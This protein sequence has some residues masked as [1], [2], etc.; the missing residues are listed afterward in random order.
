MGELED[1]VSY[2]SAD[3]TKVWNFSYPGAHLL[4]LAAD[5][6]ANSYGLPA[7]LS[8]E[9][10]NTNLVNWAKLNA[11]RKII[12]ASSGACFGIKPIETFKI[13][14]KLNLTPSETKQRFI[15]SRLFAEQSLQA[16]RADYGTPISIC[17]LF[18][19][20]GIRLLTKKQYA[21]SSFIESALRE[22]Q[23]IVKGNPETVRSYLN[24]RDMSAWLWSALNTTPSTEIL[25]IGSH[26][27]VTLG[28]VANFIATQTNSRVILQDPNAFGDEYVADN[29]MTQEHLNVSE[30]KLWEDSTLECIDFLRG[31]HERG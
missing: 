12:H 28:E 21:I 26:R 1:F 11:P 27:G 25:S 20:V 29:F 5:G 6:S 19:F 23:I 24:E 8:F 3:L 30:S 13:A 18:S 2:V 15:E 7:A 22:R 9:L 4:N 31:I 16:L 14:N 17:R 10:I